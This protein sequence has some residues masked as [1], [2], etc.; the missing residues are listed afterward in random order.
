MVTLPFQFPNHEFTG[1]YV[2]LY[3]TVYC[4]KCATAKQVAEPMIQEV[5]SKSLYEFT[6]R[7]TSENND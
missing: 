6:E 5:A 4:V 2:I 1:I 3:L 7:T